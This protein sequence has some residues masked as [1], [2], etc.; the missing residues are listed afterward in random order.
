M[1]TSWSLLFL[2]CTGLIGCNHDDC[3]DQLSTPYAY[4]IYVDESSLDGNYIYVY[5]QGTGFTNPIDSILITPDMTSAQ[6]DYPLRPKLTFE[7]EFSKDYVISTDTGAFSIYHFEMLNSDCG[8]F[9]RGKSIQTLGATYYIK[10][11]GDSTH[12]YGITL[13]P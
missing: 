1:R 4:F 10:P 3:V 2:S 12:S 9:F 6:P 5:P 11:N 7:F 13:Q 8:S